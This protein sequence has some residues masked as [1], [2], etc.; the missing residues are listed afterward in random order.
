[1]ILLKHMKLEQRME[2]PKSKKIAEQSLSLSLEMARKTG[3]P[4]EIEKEIRG[5]V[6]IRE[7]I[8]FKKFSS[9]IEP[10]YKDQKGKLHR[11]LFVTKD[12]KFL[13]KEGRERSIRELLPPKRRIYLANAEYNNLSEAKEMF[14]V[15]P[16][17][18]VDK[19][20]G[21][22]TQRGEI[23]FYGDL[24]ERGR[25]LSLLHEIG[26]LWVDRKIKKEITM[27]RIGL[28]ALWMKTRD[29]KRTI[30]LEDEILY[31][32]KDEKE[33]RPVSKKLFIKLQRLEARAERDAWAFA[34][35]KLRDL[36]RMGFDLEPELDSAEKIKEF[37]HGSEAL[38]SY[39]EELDKVLGDETLNLFVK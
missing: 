7:K 18:Y 38:G 1:M 22:I 26:H 23:A 21:D 2:I 31:C 8:G 13:D 33:E 24:K 32:P 3:K 35:K 28:D 15:Q 34:L 12:I 25:P 36:R 14:M 11:D 4:V 30:A 29:E 37:V 10:L 19:E 6:L 20:T 27:L 5:G 39:E 17:Y 16:I 9:N